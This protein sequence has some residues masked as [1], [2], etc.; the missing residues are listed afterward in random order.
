MTTATQ[1]GGEW[2]HRLGTVTALNLNGGTF[3]PTGAATITTLTY[4]GPGTFDC[5][6]GGATFAITN[7]IQMCKGTVFIDTQGQ[8]D[9]IVFKLNDCSLADV[10]IRL[11][12]D[13]TFTLS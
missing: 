7:T 5:S 3:Y 2:H 6:K 10:T 4:N 9:N 12:P 8:A 1:N 13:K 11:Q